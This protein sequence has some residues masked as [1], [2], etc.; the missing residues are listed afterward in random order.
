[1]SNIKELEK[2]LNYEF[3]SGS[4]TGEDYKQFERKYI[5][6]LKSLCNENGWRFVVAHKNHYEFS[7]FLEVDYNF[8]YFSI[9]DVRFFQN[10]WYNHILIRNAKSDRDYT[11]GQNHYTDLPNLKTNILKLIRSSMNENKYGYK[12]CYREF[13]KRK[14][15]I[16]LI[17]NS[18]DLAQWHIQWYETHTAY[19]KKKNIINKPT[20]YII[21]IKTFLGYKYLWRGCPF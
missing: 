10:Q 6:Y 19:D 3:S 14:M 18:L 7:A 8:V 15:K 12:V 9:S 21:P 5:N 1:M 11:G 4:Y 20:W 13:N 16:H 2:Y 17:C